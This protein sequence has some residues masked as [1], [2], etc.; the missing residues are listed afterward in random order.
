MSEYKLV[1]V[2]EEKPR[3]P[4]PQRYRSRF[5]GEGL[6]VNQS[7]KAWDKG[8]EARIAQEQPV[9]LPLLKQLLADRLIKHHSAMEV[10]LILD[11]LDAAIKAFMEGD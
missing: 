6:L 5:P 1:K 9:D 7:H 2:T 11:D 3:N 4:E 8:Y 10:K